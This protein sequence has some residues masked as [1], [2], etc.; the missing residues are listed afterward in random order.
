MRFTYSLVLIS[1]DQENFIREAVR[2]VLAQDCAPIEILLSDDASSD[3]TFEIIEE[4]VRNYAGP[5]TVRTNRNPQNLGIAKHINRTR[6]LATGDVIISN[7]GDDICTPH[8]VA[9]TIEEFERNAPLLAFSHAKVV[10]MDGHPAPKNYEKA[11][12]YSRQDALS[13]APSMQLYLGATCA[14]HRDLFDKYGPIENEECYEDLILGFRAALEGRISLIDE[15]LVIYRVGVG[16]TN[17]A[18]QRETPEEFHTRRLR[19]LSREIATL[20]QRLKD[21]RTFGLQENDPIVK[22]LK[23]RIR[24]RSVRQSYVS[25][26]LS[27]LR[28]IAISHPFI[29]LSAL[30]SENRRRRKAVRG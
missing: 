5:H 6:D 4:E 14:W 28:T 9:R 15:E 26:G 17:K 19:E 8:R 11:T 20:N 13:A 25:N 23:T 10:T 12:F 16:L 24:D 21:S 30:V 3:R 18:Q 22:L 29:C 7:A 2:S 27:G 1:Y